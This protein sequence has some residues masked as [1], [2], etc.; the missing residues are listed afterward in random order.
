MTIGSTRK[1]RL[2]TFGGGYSRYRR[3]A[4][5]LAVQARRSGLFDSVEPITD[6]DLR[7][8]HADFVRRNARILSRDVRGFGYWIWKPYLIDAA[9]QSSAEFLCYLDAG[10]VLNVNNAR[11]RRRFDEYH[12]IADA[13]G[14]AVM[15]NDYEEQTWCKADTLSRI[16]LYGA[17]RSSGQAEAGFL[18]MRNSSATRELVREWLNLCC[19]DGYRY[20]DDSPSQL[21]NAPGFNEH[22]HDQAILSCLCKVRGV[23]MIPAE[24]YFPTTWRTAGTDSPIWQARHCWGSRFDGTGT[25]S[26]ARRVEG[27][28]DRAERSWA[29]HKAWTASPNGEVAEFARVDRGSFADSWATTRVIRNIPQLGRTLV[30][31]GRLPMEHKELVGQRLTVW[32]DGELLIRREVTGGSF[33][34]E[35]DLP[36]QLGH[37]DVQVRI[38]ATRSFVPKRP[39]LNDDVRRLA[40]YLDELTIIDTGETCQ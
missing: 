1:T 34:W 27:F 29:D 3:A 7:R 6:G 23:E 12:E 19:D 24:A 16:G 36:R 25:D 26:L 28:V 32:C 10:A 18:L 15:R 17:E 39:G 35:L 9:L 13:N 20:V 11:A 37:G 30:L 40:Y 2:L 8:D 38:H 33:A 21:P 4:R 22:R 31:R 14:L 5:R